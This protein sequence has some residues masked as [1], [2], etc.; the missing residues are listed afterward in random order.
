[1]GCSLQPAASGFNSS[2]NNFSSYLLTW[3]HWVGFD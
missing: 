1:M 2:N 3:T